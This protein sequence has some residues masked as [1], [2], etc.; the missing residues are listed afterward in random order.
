MEIT[1]DATKIRLAAF[2]LER[3]SQVWWDW[4]KTF[5]DIE[6]IN[7]SEFH[8]LFM[9]KYF[10]ATASHAKAREFLELKQVGARGATR[11][12]TLRGAG[13]RRGGFG[14][15]RIGSGHGRSR[16]RAF[17]TSPQ[18]GLENTLA[19]G[20]GRR[21]RGYSGNTMFPSWYPRTPLRDITHGVR[22]KNI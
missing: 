20:S 9:G 16:G 6:A 12:L 8:E 1:S 11:I 5:R 15:S 3:E 13:V 22:V 4:V 10:S 18:F 7:W 19:T 2:Q 17:Y 21:G 14:T